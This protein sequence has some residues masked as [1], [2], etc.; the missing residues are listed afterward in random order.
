MRPD[1][2][3][4]SIP[5]SLETQEAK[6]GLSKIHTTNTQVFIASYSAIWGKKAEIWFSHL[7]NIKCLTAF[8][9]VICNIY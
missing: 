4:T 2:K 3:M 7:L 9:K 6:K 8:V 1:G 5:P